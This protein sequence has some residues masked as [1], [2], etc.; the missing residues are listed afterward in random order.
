MSRVG[1][2]RQGGR[3]DGILPLFYSPF[4]RLSAKFPFALSRF[5]RDFRLP[6]ANP[7]PSLKASI[8]TTPFAPISSQ[9]LP[10]E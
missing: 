8:S 4:A 10:A 6:P 5:A 9:T 2:G 3:A 7:T 1:L